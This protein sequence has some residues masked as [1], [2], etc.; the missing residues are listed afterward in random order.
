[1][2]PILALA[3]VARQGSLF[4]RVVPK[5]TGNNGYEEYVRAADAVSSASGRAFATYEGPSAAPQGA[6]PETAELY[7]R[8]AG[9]APLDVAREAAQRYGTALALVER[10][11]RK[12]VFHPLGTILP[13]TA[14]PEFSSFRTVGRLHALVARAQAADGRTDAAVGTLLEGLT[15]ADNVGRFLLIGGL[16][17]ASTSGAIYRSF[18][19]LLPRL[20]RRDAA[21]IQRGVSELLARPP[22][23]LAAVRGEAASSGA[24]LAKYLRGQPKVAEVQP[25]YP[26]DGELRRIESMGREE[27]EG[28]LR[29]ALTDLA[30]R[31]ATMERVL[32][33]PEAGW[34]KGFEGI[35]AETDARAAGLAEEL[36]RLTAPQFG[37][38]AA[39]IL[40]SRTQMRLLALHARLIEY[41]WDYG[42]WPAT[43]DVADPL[44]G[45][46]YVYEPMPDGTIRLA[47]RGTPETGEIELRTKWA[48]GAGKGE[49]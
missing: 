23:L 32:K 28:L 45:G 4:E 42:R 7:R 40:R 38:A 2:V 29:R 1:M 41:R 43:V 19:D 3:L 8:L 13:D 37:M 14:I 22:A 6:A 31:E 20:S 5:A 27:R 16:V 17:G 25:N 35:D 47:S 48:P 36:V 26:K 24:G 21:S 49:P 9:M 30:E 10:G 39:S 34:I 33:G 11:N 46:K 18:A 15:F 12:P 44:G